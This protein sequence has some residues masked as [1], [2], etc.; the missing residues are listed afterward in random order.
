[1]T[2][3]QLERRAAER[4]E[5][6][7]RSTLA[8]V[9]RRQAL[10]KAELLAAFLRACGCAEGEVAEWL[11]V[12]RRIARGA[13]GDGPAPQA[14]AGPAPGDPAPRPAGARPYRRRMVWSGAAVLG[15]LALGVGVPLLTGDGGSGQ[16]EAA[17][18][19]PL[20]TGEVLIR[21]LRSPDL[22]L[23]DGRVLR[24]HAYR[25][26]AVQRP[27]AQAVPPRTH[28]TAAGRD[29]HRIEWTHRDHG[30]GCLVVLREEAVAG[31]LE[32]WDDCTAAGL[33]HVEA[34]DGRAGTGQPVYRLR[35]TG[36]GGDGDRPRCVTLSGAGSGVAALVRP[37]SGAD[38]QKFLVGPA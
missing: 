28:L 37:C 27:C 36:P 8:D 31:L 4:G 7:A 14:A 17:A 15:A 26:V 38:D 12:R 10:P 25:T 19:A 9:L 30:T 6:L 21:P 16:P 1:M 23:T 35:L 11:A 3:R 13:P 2:Y 29:R 24:A 32:P 33:F 5:P 18:A 34:V 22:C 20:P